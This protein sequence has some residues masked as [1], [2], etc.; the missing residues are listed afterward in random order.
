MIMTSPIKNILIIAHLKTDFQTWKKRFDEDKLER[1]KTCNENNTLVGKIAPKK[2]M[3]AMFDINEKWVT[4]RK[5]SKFQRELI[6]PFC[7]QLEI[8]SIEN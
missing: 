7:E 8:Y 5:N 3:L 2:V 4:R 6:E 1:S